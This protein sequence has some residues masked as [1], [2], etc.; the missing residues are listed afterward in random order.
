MV[1][2]L[3]CSWGVGSLGMA[4]MASGHLSQDAVP[5]RS[6]MQYLRPPFKRNAQRTYHTPIAQLPTII[7]DLVTLWATYFVVWCV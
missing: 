4:G 7:L 2:L 3:G 1:A 5:P 6:S